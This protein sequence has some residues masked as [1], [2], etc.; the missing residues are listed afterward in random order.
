MIGDDVIVGAGSVVTKSIPP[1]EVWA[2]SPAKKICSLEEYLA[3]HSGKQHFGKD[4]YLSSNLSEG[5]KNEIRQAV[6]NG[7]AYIV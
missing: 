6:E 7:T 4:Y 2:G 5:K 3:K 1:R